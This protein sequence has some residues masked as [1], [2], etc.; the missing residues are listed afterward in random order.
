MGRMRGWGLLLAVAVQL[1]IFF[2]WSRLG[3]E[4]ARINLDRYADWS[5]QYSGAL[6]RPLSAYFL[7]HKKLAI[8]GDVALPAVPTNSGVKRWGL[9]ADTTLLVELD[10]TVDGHPVLLRYVPLV[11]SASG[12]FYDCVSATSPVQ[13]GRFCRGEVLKTEADIPAQLQANTQALQNLPAVQSASGVALPAGATAGSVVVVP[14]N[15][16]DLNQCGFQCVQPQ[17]CVTPRPLAWAR[18]TG[19]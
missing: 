5:A 11:R 17:S 6:M 2:S 9:Q 7:Q 16:A 19:W 18:A 13:V 12:I 1:L 15:A 14:A 8:P 4:K 3:G 10:A